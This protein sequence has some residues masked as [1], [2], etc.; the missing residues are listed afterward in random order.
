LV[1]LA[2]GAVLPL[3]IGYGFLHDSPGICVGAPWAYRDLRGRSLI[4]AD[5]AFRR[6]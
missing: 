1:A 3:W 4:R 2:I 6:L 5:A